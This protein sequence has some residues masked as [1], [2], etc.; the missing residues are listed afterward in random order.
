MKRLVILITVMAILIVGGGLSAQIA[1]NNNNATSALP[2]LLKQ[3]DNP[4]A[5]VFEAT[6]WQAEQFFLFVGFLL[7]NMIGIGVTIM[8]ILWLLNRGALEAK[9]EAEQQKSP[10]S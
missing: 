9:A 7:F 4:D 10:T 3:T 2:G 6:P 1:A 8:A 5:S